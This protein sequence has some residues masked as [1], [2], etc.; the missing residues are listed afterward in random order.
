VFSFRGRRRDFLLLVALLPGCLLADDVVTAA[1]ASNFASTAAEIS[2]AFTENTGIPVRISVGST[3]KLY[4]QIVNGAPFDVFLAADTERPLLLEQAG[5][6]ERGSRQSYAVGRLVLWSRD[7]ALEG[8]SCREALYRGEYS[9]IAIANPETAP[10]GSAAREYLKMAGLWE[11][12]S[13]RAVYGENISQTLHFVATGNATLGFVARSQLVL[14]NLPPAVCTWSVPESPQT[15]LHQQVVLLTSAR[16]NDA[17][18]RF[19]G[20]LV[21]SEARKIIGQH[22]YG[23]PN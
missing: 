8:K 1:I 5:H 21:S 12:A 11:Y 13:G 10:Y 4:A 9:K 18:R 14:A 23:I 3:G 2:A 20:F 16:G 7:T 17:A 22:G 15:A 19:V 6:A